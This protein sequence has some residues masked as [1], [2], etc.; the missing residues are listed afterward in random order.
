MHKPPQ[1]I[2]ADA[3]HITATQQPEN[4]MLNTLKTWLLKNRIAACSIAIEQTER[5]ARHAEQKAERLAKREIEL[6]I[7]YAQM[8]PLRHSIIMPE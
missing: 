4:D 2:V 7:R 3:R 1:Q 6:R 8:H 5:M